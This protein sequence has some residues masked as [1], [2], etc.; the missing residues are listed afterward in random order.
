MDLGE[1]ESVKEGL[2]GI[3]GEKLYPGWNIWEKINKLILNREQILLVLLN[4]LILLV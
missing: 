3:E 2:G 1:R 4:R